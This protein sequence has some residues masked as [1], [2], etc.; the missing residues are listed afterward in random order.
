MKIACVAQKINLNQVLDISVDVHKDTL[1]IF[2]ECE[3]KEYTDECSNRT[4]T[5]EK[6]LRQ[7]HQIA[8]E[9]G[10]KNLRI[11]CEPTGQ[12]QNKL[13][14]TA[15]RLG[16]LTCYVNTESVAKFRVIETND[17]GKT[18]V[19]DPRVIQSL[20][21]MGKTI[22]HRILN[23]DYL[24]LRKLGTMYD[25][26]DVTVVSLR[27]KLSCVLM[28]LFV[29]YS[30]KQDFLYDVSGRALVKEY[31][32]NPYRIIQ[33]GFERFS[34]A[35]RK[36]APRIRLDSIRRLWNDAESSVRNELP[37][38]YIQTLEGQF[39]Q[40]FEDFLRH[41][42]RKKIIEEKMVAILARLRE[43]DPN[44]PPP[45]K[46][47]ISAKNLARLLGETGPLSDFVNW[48]KIMRYGGLNIC[49]RQSGKYQG[50]NKISKKGRSL[51]RKI[52][53]Q[54]VLP[55]VKRGN[56]YG[57]FYHKKREKMP[58]KKAMTVVMRQFLKKFFGWYKS[59]GAFN[60][61]RFFTCESQYAKA[62]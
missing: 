58:G 25:D 43:E 48:R 10:R 24:L 60:K 8:L 15:R 1:N 16:F 42:E 19:K 12:Y 30:F 40:L 59:G 22:R 44:I 37:A 13:L 34:K 62:A 20:G 7:Y 46:G 28:E 54:I 38:S 18:D 52:L 3:G 53:S 5:I 27:C 50:V 9:N 4:S 31:G 61:E 36:A 11:I 47:V 2:F 45:T 23:E 35:M 6:R 14:R 29:D 41:E 57:E 33:N 51:L 55:L 39:C 32:C 21:Q 49:M 17:A 56:L 26:E